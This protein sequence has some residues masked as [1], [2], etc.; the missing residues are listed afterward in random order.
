MKKTIIT[1]VLGLLFS[2]SIFAADFAVDVKTNN[3]DLGQLNG[4]QTGAYIP[5]PALQCVTPYFWCWLNQPA[6]G[7]IP[8]WCPSYYGPVGGYTGYV[9]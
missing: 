1:L 2:A 6:P 8:C 5:P 3:L 4:L 7:G 9:Y